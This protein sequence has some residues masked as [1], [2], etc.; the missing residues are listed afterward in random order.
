MNYGLSSINWTSYKQFLPENVY[1]RYIEYWGEVSF[2]E[3]GCSKLI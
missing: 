3:K 2:L 1:D